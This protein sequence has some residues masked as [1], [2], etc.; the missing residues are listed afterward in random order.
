MGSKGIYSHMVD[1]HDTDGNE[2]ETISQNNHSHTLLQ[3]GGVPGR[4]D[5]IRPE[6]AIPQ[7]GVHHRGWG[8]YGWQRGDY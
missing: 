6:P 5:P 1:S 2:N 8:E 7:L 4:D 3:P